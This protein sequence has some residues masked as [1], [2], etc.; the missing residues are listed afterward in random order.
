[1]ELEC[2]VQNYAWGKL[3]SGSVVAQLLKSSTPEFVLEDDKPY[4]EFWMGT[5]PNGPSILKQEQIPLSKFIEEN[6]TTLGAVAKECGPN[7]P[8]LFK[9]LSVRKALSIQVHPNKEQAERLHQEQPEIYKDPNHKPEIAIALTTFEALCGFRPIPEIRNFLKYLPE[10]RA[11]IGENEVSHFLCCDEEEMENSLR[12]CFS[13]LMSQGPDLIAQQLR[14]LLER[15]SNLDQA[16]RNLL[17]A[18]LLERLHLDYPGDVGCFGIYLF[19]YLILQPGE[20][21]YL[22]AN[23]LHAYLFGDCVECMACSD[24]VV[25]AGLTPKFKDVGTLIKMVSYASKPAADQKFQ[26]LREN[27]CTE[28]FL[29]PIQDF[30]VARITIPPGRSTFN[31]I[32]RKS[33]SI[34]I[35]IN[36]EVQLLDSR[37]FGRGSVLFIPANETINFKVLHE[38]VS[39]V[40]FQAFANIP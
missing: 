30:A 6:K 14:K 18:K 21:L 33:A 38:K 39:T 7:L 5:H 19:N 4:A 35:I 29:P 1:M 11:A 17:N 8:Y 24:N 9:V 32:P 26:A 27:E 37:I 12:K 2:S 28:V 20:A 16:T 23:E 40:M 3:G 10:L 34:L 36:G 25:R 13:S 22:G 15:L 31:T